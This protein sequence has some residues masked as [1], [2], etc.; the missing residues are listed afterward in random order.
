MALR[1]IRI[2]PMDNICQYD[3][4]EFS[5]AI[6]TD[7]PIKAGPPVA[8][9]DVVRLSDIVPGIGNLVS[10]AGASADN[11]IARF[12]GVSGKILQ[13]SVPTIDDAGN[14]NFHGLT[15]IAMG[16]D[17]GATLPV[18]PTNTFPFFVHTPTGR[19]VLMQYDGT[20]WTPIFAHGP[21]TMY[22]DKTDGT[23]GQNYGG[24]VDGGAFA[25]WT[26][27]FA[28]IPPNFSGHVNINGNNETYSETAILQGKKATGPYNIY[29][30]GTRTV[31]ESLTAD[32]GC[33][34]GSYTFNTH[35]QNGKI[36]RDAG[37]WM[38]NQR[39]N[40][41]IR[42]TSGNN[43]GESLVIDNND[44]TSVRPVGRFLGGAI[45]AGD[46][47]N[48]EE[49]GTEIT[50]F[51]IGD[52]QTGII[53]N[54][55]KLGFTAGT[56][57]T[58]FGRFIKAR[59]NCV[60]IPFASASSLWTNKANDIEFNKSYIQN[61]R[62]FIRNHTKLNS[63]GTKHDNGGAGAR[64]FKIND[65]AV[66]YLSDGTIID[67]LD[68]AS[69]I[70]VYPAGLGIVNFNGNMD[71][72]TTSTFAPTVRNCITGVSVILNS[73][74]LSV[75]PQRVHFGD[76]RIQTAVQENPTSVVVNELNDTSIDFSAYGVSVGDKVLNTT[77]Y[78][79]ALVTVVNSTTRLTLDAH[80]F[81]QTWHRYRILDV[82]TLCTTDS[83]SA[84]GG[85]IG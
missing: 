34:P 38:T 85:Q 73:I 52:G 42:F 61:C 81:T 39:Q 40:K 68:V 33:L 29:L 4:G 37:T 47:F 44:T 5:E 54:D 63:G 12:N 82:D 8:G 24:A 16:C 79:T 76:E 26:F 58:L 75:N 18:S 55:I 74:A 69:S 67:G 70:G 15:A 11:A 78:D 64:N 57:S 72:T 30:N 83:S 10:N 36:I 21:M 45:S 49:L 31:I 17:H 14:L 7:Q 25:S 62:V 65:G 20:A 66:L 23:D 43:D 59:F 53:V 28:Q 32:A 80:I 50:D 60:S 27:A 77:T 56:N 3:D 48:I 46:T 13:D 19:T 6:E 51:R 41:W 35:Y 71:S 84:T 1:Q 2:G 9:E 22:V